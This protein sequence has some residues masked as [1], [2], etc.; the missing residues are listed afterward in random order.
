MTNI[1]LIGPTYAGKTSL[2][3]KFSCYLAKIEEILKKEGIRSAIWRAY[4]P[5]ATFI[6][7][8]DVCLKAEPFETYRNDYLI[9]NP[10]LGEVRWVTTSGYPDA[11][12]MREDF[13][14]A[15]ESNPA[16]IIFVYDI[17]LGPEG[18]L[19]ATKVLLELLK[20]KRNEPLFTRI[21]SGVPISVNLN[22]VDIAIEKGFDYERLKNLAN[23]ISD[24]IGKFL[25]RYFKLRENPFEKAKIYLTYAG[26]EKKE[27][28]EKYE[29]EI[30]FMFY[31]S[32]KEFL[33]DVGLKLFK[34]VI[35]KI[36]I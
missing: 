2:L 16:R 27:G 5:N 26:R 35:N 9:L 6:M 22:K 34:S 7:A 23:E 13:Y 17:N 19:K 36:K 18:N 3:I 4:F 15:L 14:S 10:Y 21:L 28:L 12:I 29:N 31:E 8:K 25:M 33:T 30:F 11:G 20:A 24:T 32:C 1:V